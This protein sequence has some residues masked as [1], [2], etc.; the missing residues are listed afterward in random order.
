[1]V[2]ASVMATVVTNAEIV[3]LL[4]NNVLGISIDVLIVSQELEEISLIVI[5]IG[6]WNVIEADYE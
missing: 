4:I 1:M 2:D 5:R 6:Y 3:A